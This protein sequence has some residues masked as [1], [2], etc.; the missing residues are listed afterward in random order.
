VLLVARRGSTVDAVV[1]ALAE[2]GGTAVTGDVR[3]LSSL[4]A[5]A[6]DVS[7]EAI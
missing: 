6:V 2:P 7:I 4:A 1:V 3:D 5:R